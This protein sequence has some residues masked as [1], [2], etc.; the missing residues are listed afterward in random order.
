ME[1]FITLIVIIFLCF[2]GFT[3]YFFFK[4]LGFVINATRLYRRMIERQDA[5][6]KLLV[7]IR[8]NTKNVDERQL[9]FSGEIKQH[10]KAQQPQERSIDVDENI[11]RKDAPEPAKKTWKCLCGAENDES[12]SNC[13]VC[14]KYK[15]ASKKPSWA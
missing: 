4:S 15:G 12:L 6:I 1:G 8:D 10:S 14:S 7:D 5:V 3:I 9:N 13:S 11:D 2:I